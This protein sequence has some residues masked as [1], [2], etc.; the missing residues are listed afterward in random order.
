MMLTFQERD[1]MTTTQTSNETQE[2]QKTIVMQTEQIGGSD[3]FDRR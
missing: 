2:Q 3:N 1:E